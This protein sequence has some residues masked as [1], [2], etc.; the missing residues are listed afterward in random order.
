MTNTV[1][2]EV[3]T[4]S[5]SKAFKAAIRDSLSQP[6]S[7]SRQILCSGKCCSADNYRV[8]VSMYCAKA[9]LHFAS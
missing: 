2:A 8:F 4:G 9:F 6:E 5:T 3:A 7:V 1:K